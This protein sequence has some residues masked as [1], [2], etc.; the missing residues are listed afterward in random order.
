MVERAMLIGITLPGE[1]E[2]T[3]RGLLDELR[4]LVTTLEIGIVHEREVSIRKPQA[5]FLVGSGKADELIEEA[6]VAR[7]RRDRLRQRAH[8]CATAQ[9]GTSR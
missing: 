5:K 8:P 1:D 6:K 4:E 3:T 9:L 7:L 2:Q